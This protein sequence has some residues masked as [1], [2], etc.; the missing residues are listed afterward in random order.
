[1]P[2]QPG[3]L[4]ATPV[5]AMQDNVH[6]GVGSTTTDAFGALVAGQLGAPGDVDLLRAFQFG[7]LPVLEDVNGPDLLRTAVHQAAFGSKPGATSWE[8]VPADSAADGAG[9]FVPT[10]QASPSSP[11]SVTLTVDEAA[12]LSDLN[13][14]QSGFEAA[15]RTL[16]GY[17]K[18]LYVLWW[19]W[20]R[21]LYQ[22]SIVPLDGFEPKAY[23]AAVTSTLPTLISAA[24]A[25]VNR[26]AALVPQPIVQPGDT[27]QASFQ[28]GVSAFANAK[29]LDPQKSL[30]P[31]AESR[32][33]R[34]G[35]PVIV[36]SGVEPAALPDPSALLPCRLD[37]SVISALTAAGATMDTTTLATTLGPLPAA[38]GMP[39]IVAALAVEAFLL[40]P[41]NAAVAARAVGADESTVQTAM[42][43]RP[44]SAYHG[45]IPAND[46]SAWTQQPWTGLLMEW[47]V[48]YV[49]IPQQTN[50]TPNWAFDGSDYRFTG[51]YGGFGSDSL[52]PLQRLGGIAPLTPEAQFAFGGQLKRFVDTYVTGHPDAPLDAIA[53]G[54]LYDAIEALDGWKFMSQALTGFGDL[55]ALIDTRAQTGPDST[56]AAAVGSATNGVAY[57]PVPTYPFDAL[58]RGQFVVQQLIVYDT[59][60][61]VLQVVGG[62]GTTDPQNFVP[63]LDSALVPEKPVITKNPARLIEVRPRLMQHARLDL[64]LVDAGTDTPVAPGSSADPVIA[65]LLPNHLDAGVLLY[66]PDGTALGEVAL[67]VDAL[68]ARAAIWQPPPHSAITFADVTATAPI[69]ASIISDP[70]FVA[71]PAFSAFLDVIDTTL[72]SIDPLGNRADQNMSVLIGRPLGLVRTALRL[73]LDGPPITDVSSWSSVWPPPTPEFLGYPFPVR[74][75][76]LASRQDGVIGLWRDKA[77]A[78]FDSVAAPETGQTYIRQ[79][80]PVGQPTGQNYPTLTFGD[81]APTYVNL[82]LDPRAAAHAFTGILPMA[83][84]AVPAT[85]VDKALSAL[86]LTFTIGSA[87]THTEGDPAAIWLPVPAE[88]NG[89]WSWWERTGPTAWTSSDLLRATTDARLKDYPN[90]VRDAF[91]QLVSDLRRQS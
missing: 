4:P 54:H 9:V 76:D 36:L 85:F 28:R 5:T 48:G 55:V 12:W 72:W 53:V 30:K 31:V 84:V 71:E 50:G 59:F 57:Q 67:R 8:I 37:Q 65:W 86:E 69:L 49:A 41:A 3:S 87:L 45:T 47:Q 83:T 79:V 89:T 35:D 88:Q 44:A 74:L 73:V 61:Q 6:V 77:Y 51:P 23:E 27:R 63:V 24:V 1:M 52:A 10:S 66:A 80:G 14:A 22:S 82:L 15:Q 7:L 39:A 90:T 38:N 16:A 40:D 42:S 18:A 21:G 91:L 75:G 43:T 33:W 13:S 19:K 68:G 58:R 26:Q 78:A 60:G 20:Q 46:L 81:T 17:R 32:L 34:S 2:W 64:S 25:E 29:G 70:A 11:P 62:T 56:V